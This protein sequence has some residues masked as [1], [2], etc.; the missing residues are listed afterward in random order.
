MTSTAIFLMMS[1]T[2]EFRF[3]EHNYSTIMIFSV[4]FGHLC[5]DPVTYGHRFRVLFQ[6]TAQ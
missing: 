5:L 4:T 3:I 6:P 2:I 1:E